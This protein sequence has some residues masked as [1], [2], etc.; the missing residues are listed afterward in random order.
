M[1]SEGTIQLSKDMDGQLNVKRKF[2]LMY[3]FRPDLSL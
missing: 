2:A 1:H 3:A